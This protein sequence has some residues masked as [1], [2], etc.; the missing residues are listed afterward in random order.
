[1]AGEVGKWRGG[2]CGARVVNES[3]GVEE[4]TGGPPYRCGELT[5]LKRVYSVNVKAGNAA[6]S[7]TSTSV[8]RPNGTQYLIS[9]G[10]CQS[11]RGE[12]RETHG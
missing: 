11:V 10:E 4:R 8:P 5:V 3:G 6:Q 7:V 12:E 2:V 1:M 9:P